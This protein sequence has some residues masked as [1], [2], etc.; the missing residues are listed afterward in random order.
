MVFLHNYRD[1]S[2]HSKPKG[3]EAILQEQGYGLQVV[4]GRVVSRFWLNAQQITAVL[5]ASMNLIYSMR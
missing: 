1:F 2:L 3:L 5:A 4:K